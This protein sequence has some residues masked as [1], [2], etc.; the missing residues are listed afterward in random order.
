MAR[1]NDLANAQQRQGTA[2]KELVE[3]IRSDQDDDEEDEEEPV[4]LEDDDNKDTH[5]KLSLVS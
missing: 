5:R 3:A 4:N 1:V 2:F